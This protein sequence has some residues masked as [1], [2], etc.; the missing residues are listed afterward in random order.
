[1]R[2]ILK[3]KEVCD[4]LQ[5]VESFFEFQFEEESRTLTGRIF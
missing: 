1:M 5:K 4:F 2:I 3:S